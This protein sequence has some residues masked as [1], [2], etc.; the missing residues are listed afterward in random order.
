MT[1]F[2]SIKEKFWQW[3]ERTY[4]FNLN[5]SAT[6]FLL[7]IVHLIWMT[8]DVV[9]HKLFDFPQVLHGGVPQFLLAVV[10][11]LEI[12]TIV[13]VSLIYIRSY[14]T[15]HNKKALWYLFLLNTQWIHIFWITDEF[16]LSNFE[17]AQVAL[18]PL[19]AWVAIG[20]DYLEIPVMID[21]IKKVFKQGK[22]GFREDD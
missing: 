19:L 20:I 15:E 3:Y 4:K 9:L 10:D 16:V 17:N 13:A 6:V 14:R 8:N 11:Y 5:F 1:A 2:Q 18:P 7:Q 22:Q 21:T 12:P